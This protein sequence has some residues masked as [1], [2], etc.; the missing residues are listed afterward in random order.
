[1]TSSP[2]PP[3]GTQYAIEGGGWSAVLTEIGAAL[4]VLACGSRAVVDGF[5]EERMCSGFRGLPLLPWPNRIADGRYTFAGVEHQ[6]PISRVAENNAI[7]GLTLWQPWRLARRET[8]RVALALDLAPQPGYPFALSLEVEYAL[9]ASGLEV[10]TRATNRGETD[11]PFGAGFHPYLLPRATLD[12]AR[13]RVPASAYLVPDE[14]GLPKDERTVA[15]TPFDFRD[16]DAIGDRRL[17]HCLGPLG[18][19]DAAAELVLDDLVVWIDRRFHWVQLYSGDKLP[20]GERRRSLAIEPMTCP[21]NAFRTGRDLIVLHPG[22]DVTL[23]WGL[24]LR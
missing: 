1:M 18:T 9:G 19:G 24:T 2:R 17:D 20:I 21:P 4:R 22:D 13:L 3:S 5:A 11:L 16:G 23:R 6:L 10:T 14:R 8:S 15:G 7:H 12:A